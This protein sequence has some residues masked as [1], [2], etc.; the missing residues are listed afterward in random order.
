MRTSYAD[1]VTEYYSLEVYKK[2]DIFFLMIPTTLSS[3]DLSK[4]A[5]GELREIIGKNYGDELADS[6]SEEDL[7]T[8]G[9]FLLE[10]M[11]QGLKLRMEEK[12]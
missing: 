8:I 3:V 10:V 6:F 5:L 7:N 4:R 12:Y 9:L 11:A 2:Y 1:L